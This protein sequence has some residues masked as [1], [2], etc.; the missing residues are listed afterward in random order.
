MLPKYDCYEK[1]KI[2]LSTYGNYAQR[3]PSMPISKFETGL[4]PKSW[5]IAWL[6]P[7]KS[8][9]GSTISEDLSDGIP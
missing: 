4:S 5:S 3:S 1:I 9:Y 7:H 8:T 2:Y 6:S